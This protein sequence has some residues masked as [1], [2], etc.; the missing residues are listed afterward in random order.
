MA[1]MVIGTL[2][3]AF[4]GL[5]ILYALVLQQNAEEYRENGDWEASCQTSIRGAHVTY[6][7]TRG[8]ALSVCLLVVGVFL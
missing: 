5:A 2:G 1:L 3:C 7:S 4:S 6:W 8:L